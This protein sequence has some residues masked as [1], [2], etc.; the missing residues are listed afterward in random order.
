MPALASTCRLLPLSLLASA[1]PIATV[2]RDMRNVRALPP[3]LLVTD[4]DSTLTSRDSVS[5]LVALSPIAAADPERVDDVVAAYLR[6]YAE[7]SRLLEAGDLE[8]A[9]Q[10]YTALEHASLDRVEAAEI[11]RG[12]SSAAIA[13][14][15]PAVE[16][17]DGAAE[18]LDA[19]AAAGVEVHVCSANWSE[20]WIRCALGSAAEH[21]AGVCCNELELEQTGLSSGRLRREVVSADDKLLVFE[22]LESGAAQCSAGRASCFVGDALGDFRAILAADVGIV[23]GERKELRRALRLAGV[24]TVPDLGAARS[25]GGV[26]PG[27]YAARDWRQVKEV[28]RLDLHKR[29]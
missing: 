25:A 4:F 13:R 26:M 22:R 29:R 20:H 10:R 23:I 8:P 18:A 3:R 15:A 27:V 19:A 14:S 11:L 28:L 16:L 2:A 24:E 17:R 7:V 5:E 6:D 12:V 21:L 9:L 1:R